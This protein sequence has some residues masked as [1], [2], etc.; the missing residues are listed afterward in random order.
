M[1]KKWHNCTDVKEGVA[2]LQRCEGGW[3]GKALQG[4]LCEEE[5]EC[6]EHCDC[7]A[8]GGRQSTPNMDWKTGGNFTSTTSDPP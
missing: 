4:I 2:Q 1:K 3:Q 8:I 7:E 5:C 6:E